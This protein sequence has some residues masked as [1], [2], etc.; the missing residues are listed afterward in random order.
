MKRHI[1]HAERENQA[2]ECLNLVHSKGKEPSEIVMRL[3]K[4]LTL[5]IKTGITHRTQGCESAN[6]WRHQGTRTLQLDVKTA[7][8]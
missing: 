8:T 3:S 2:I 6:T 1:R 4:T 5:N 7:D